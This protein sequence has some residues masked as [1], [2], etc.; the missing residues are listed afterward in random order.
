MAVPLPTLQ[1][2]GK[3]SPFCCRAREE[4]EFLGEKPDRGNRC[5]PDPALSKAGCAEHRCSGTGAS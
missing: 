2:A 4:A 1:A 5:A 3:E